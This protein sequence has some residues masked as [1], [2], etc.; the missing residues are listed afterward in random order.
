MKGYSNP[1]YHHP[2]IDQLFTLSLGYACRFFNAQKE[3][4]DVL[5]NQKIS[6]KGEE[7]EEEK[8]VKPMVKTR[9]RKFQFIKET[10]EKLNKRYE[11]EGSA[12]KVKSKSSIFRKKKLSLARDEDHE[13][14]SFSKNSKSKFI[15]Q[16]QDSSKMSSISNTR[17]DDINLPSISLF[18]TAGLVE[19]KEKKQKKLKEEASEKYFSPQKNRFS[20][21]HSETDSLNTLQEEQLIDSN[22]KK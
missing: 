11:D 19:E 17:K 14:F 8:N 6:P 21:G 7:R 3:L 20:N 1:K 9:R 5:A 16:S 4:I 13:E 18:K 15:N 2:L 12:N 10:P 22:P